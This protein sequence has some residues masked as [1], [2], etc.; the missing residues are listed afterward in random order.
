MGA[1]AAERG[2]QGVQLHT[3]EIWWVCKVPILHTLAQINLFPFRTVSLSED[4]RGAS[5]YMSTY[6]IP[7]LNI[8]DRQK[9]A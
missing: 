6:L 3:L 1:G 7:I 9:Y 2:V 4:T 5:V 8:D